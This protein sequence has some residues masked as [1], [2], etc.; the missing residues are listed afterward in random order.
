MQMQGA[1]GVRVFTLEEGWGWTFVAVEHWNAECMG[2]HVCKQGTRFAALEP[3]FQG[4]MATVGAVTAD[5]GRGLWSVLPI[6]VDVISYVQSQD[7]RCTKVVRVRL[8]SKPV[9]YSWFLSQVGP[10]VIN[11]GYSI[12]ADRLANVVAE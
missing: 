8:E 12:G 7:F 3:I 6:L 2:W 5:A 1:G 10:Q 9:S 4:L 11:P